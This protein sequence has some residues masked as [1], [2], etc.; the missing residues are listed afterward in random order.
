MAFDPFSKGGAAISEISAFKPDL[1]L[2]DLVMAQVDGLGPCRELKK[3]S[4]LDRMQI[5]FVSSKI[6]A[7]W[8]LNA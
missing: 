5:I 7:Y 3:C 2:T 1:L 6:E 4:N 8:R